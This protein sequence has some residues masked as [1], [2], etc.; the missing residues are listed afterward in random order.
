[1][2]GQN[3][4]CLLVEAVN[5]ETMKAYA[6]TAILEEESLQSLVMLVDTISGV[7]GVPADSIESLV[8]ALTADC[9]F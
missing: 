5:E 3:D 9:L 8:I 7:A 6:G 4:E 2:L 1:M